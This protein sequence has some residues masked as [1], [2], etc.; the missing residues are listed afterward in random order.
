MNSNDVREKL[1]SFFRNNILYDESINEIDGDESLIDNGYIDSTGIIGLVTFI[2]KT[3][4]FKVKDHEILPENFDSINRLN[5][6][7]NSKIANYD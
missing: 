6:Y 1:M 4:N 5:T 7:I 2:E 3:F